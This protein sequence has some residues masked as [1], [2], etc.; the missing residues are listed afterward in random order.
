M[1][2]NDYLKIMMLIMLNEHAQKMIAILVA[3]ESGGVQ[4]NVIYIES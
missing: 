2:E 3:E 4:I 1:S